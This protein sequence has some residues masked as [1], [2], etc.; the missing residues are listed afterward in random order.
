MNRLNRFT[1]KAGYTQ[2]LNFRY[3]FL[4]GQMNG[5]GYQNTFKSRVR[6]SLDGRPRQDGMSGG[7]IHFYGAFADQGIRSPN[8]G[9][10]GV[11]H[12]IYNDGIPALH[13]SDDVHDFR[14]VV[15]HSPLVDNGQIRSQ[16][17]RISSSLLNSS[18]IGLNA[19][20]IFHLR[21][22][23]VLEKYGHGKQ[24]VYGDVK[25]TLNLARMEIHG[26]QALS[27]RRGK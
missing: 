9:S 13:V 5:I 3:S 6:D 27:T 2:N 12:V 1:Q 10:G 16:S 18:S 22:G 17:F 19:H 26:K 8:Q 4:F 21:V 14:F 15:V 25:E 20:Q 24:M 7:C 23:N 11:D